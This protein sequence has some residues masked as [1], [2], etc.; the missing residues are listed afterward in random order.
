M[1]SLIKK[2]LLAITITTL[3]GCAKPVIQTEYVEVKVPV[4]YKL[5]RPTRPSYLKTDSVPVYLLKLVE[6]TT[7]LE[8]I[9]DENNKEE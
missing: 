7:K 9:I 2:S 8:I 4:R 6:Y 1:T 5:E 3:M